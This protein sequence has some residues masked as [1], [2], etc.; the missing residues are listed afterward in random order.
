MKNSKILL[1]VFV[2]ALL[3]LFSFAGKDEPVSVNVKIELM[4][5]TKFEHG[6]LTI[7]ETGQTFE[8]KDA[9]D[10]T[11]P[12]KKGKYTF[13]FTSETSHHLSYPGKITAKENTVTITL[14]TYKL[15]MKEY[16]TEENWQQLLKEDKL[17]F[18]HFGIAPADEKEF[19]EKYR[20]GLKSEG[21]VITPTLSTAVKTNN[22]IVADYLSSKFAEDWKKELKFIP[23]GLDL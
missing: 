13:R 20:I 18:V 8:I 11:I 9:K 4:P 5:D 19:F 21:C 1:S 17:K 2:F 22:K 23:F 7:K 16:A 6:T 10:F 15:Q 14:G 12:L 3:V